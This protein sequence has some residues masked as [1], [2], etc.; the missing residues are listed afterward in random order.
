M[1]NFESEARN[2][3]N[4]LPKLMLSI[5]CVEKENNFNYTLVQPD[6]TQPCVKV[7]D[8]AKGLGLHLSMRVLGAKFKFSVGHGKF[9]FPQLYAE[10]ASS[11][12]IPVVSFAIKTII[13]VDF[14]KYH[15]RLLFAGIFNVFR[16]FAKKWFQER[17]K[18]EVLSADPCFLL[19]MPYFF[20]FAGAAGTFLLGCWA[21]YCHKFLQKKNGMSMPLT[22]SLQACHRRVDR[23]INRR[24]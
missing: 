4:P 5:I 17:Q 16:P 14:K 18:C 3:R 10:I 24:S 7:V 2:I 19:S 15:A 21:W 1:Q 13:A 9:N 22:M 20:V 12:R 6:K 23:E 8:F 11:C